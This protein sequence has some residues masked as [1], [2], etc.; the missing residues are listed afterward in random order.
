MIVMHL[1]VFFYQDD[2]DDDSLARSPLTADDDGATDE[3]FQLTQQQWLLQSTAATG[4]LAQW[5]KHTRVS[6]TCS[7]CRTLHTLLLWTP[8]SP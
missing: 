8:P 2:R 7:L 3:G 1:I 4:D 6:G 5:E